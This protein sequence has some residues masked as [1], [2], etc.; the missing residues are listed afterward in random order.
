MMTDI[1]WPSKLPLVLRLDGLTGQKEN[2]VVRTQ[3]D[4]GPAKV[5]RRYTVSSKRFDGSIIVTE[6]QR[7][8]L[9]YFYD[10]TLGSGALR[11]VMRDPQTLILSE[12]RFREV[13]RE[14]SMDGLWKITLPLEKM[15]A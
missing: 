13:Y 11:F 1:T 10:H 2:N 14:E 6:A 3:M 4:A 9:E 7:E 5:R 15:N 12:F 8:I